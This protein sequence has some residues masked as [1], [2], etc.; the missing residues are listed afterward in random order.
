MNVTLVQC[1][2]TVG[3]LKGNL[4]M[5]LGH[6]SS[7]VS[8][9]NCDVIVFPELV[10][11]GY[12]PRDLLYNQS[13]W[14]SHEKL[15]QKLHQAV[16]NLNRQ[17]TVIFGGLHQVQQTYGRMAKYNAAFIVDKKYGVRVV[18]KRLLPCY[19]VFDETRY[20][21]SGIGDPYFAI[22]IE[23]A[24]KH[25]YNCDVII[26][27]DMW[28]FKN[29][30][31]S[32]WLPATYTEDPVSNLKGD[33][34]IFIIN[35]SPYWENKIETTVGI[36][37]EIANEL[38]RPVCWVN[39]VGAHDDIIT[40]GYSMVCGYGQTFHAALFAEDQFSCVIKSEIQSS[41]RWSK[42]AWLSSGLSKSISGLNDNIDA[43]DFNTW[44][45][46]A[47]L[48][49][50]LIDY[51]R[52]T[53]FADVIIGLSGG[54]D[55]ALVCA[56]AAM[57]LGSEHVHGVSMPSKFSSEGSWHDAEELARN[58][59]IKTFQVIPISDIHQSVRN[60]ILSGGRQEF[61]NS[62]TDENIQPRCRMIMLM[63]LSNDERKLLLTTGNKSELAM[64]Y[65]TL[66][67]D[68]AGGLAIIS[69]ILKTDVFKMCK[70]IN[71]YSGKTIIPE[72]TITK[73][74]SAELRPN[75][76]DTDS[77]PDYEKLDPIIDMIMTDI[78]LNTIKLQT[79]I[80]E[81]VEEIAKKINAAEFKRVQ[82][83]IGAKV[84]SRSFGSGRRVPIAA[85]LTII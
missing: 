62:L 77:L 39:Q 51:C 24:D 45:D 5:M 41:S 20:F 4:A 70:F 64:G 28:N 22:P 13:L 16:L 68:M 71:K 2:P 54:I 49:L 34:P 31:N 26:C 17:V 40:G 23:T 73:P 84:R 44:C 46:L 9:N 25:V 32:R 72:N 12:P 69:D 27:E 29:S 78:P 67:G 7:I 59:N 75:Q 30:S 8:Q 56:I 19:D 42:A 3:D 11:V 53:G 66:Y 79:Q 48:K 14:D 81:R 43:S 50:Y 47:A 52:K 85:K 83:P 35:G 55:S 36:V 38:N 10:T 18:H 21:Q 33:G 6:I 61:D 58:L 80:P 74:P 65:A 63:A 15:V 1:N 57:A 60:T 37:E 76:K 82:A